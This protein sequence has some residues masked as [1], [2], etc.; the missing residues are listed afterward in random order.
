MLGDDKGRGIFSFG[1]G[2]YT[3]SPKTAQEIHG[4]PPGGEGVVTIPEV[5]DGVERGTVGFEDAG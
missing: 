5:E 1:K 3:P 4:E 2:E